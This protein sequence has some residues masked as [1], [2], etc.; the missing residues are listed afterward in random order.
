MNKE[1]LRVIPMEENFMGDK[2]IYDTVWGFFQLNSYK[3]NNGERFVY[4]TN[5]TTPTNI[6]RSIQKVVGYKP[7]GKEIYN[8]SLS[9]VKN[10]IQI[11]KK[12]GLIWEGK[13]KDNYNREVDV[14]FLKSDFKKFQYINYETLRFLL[15]STNGNTIKIYVYLLYKQEWKQKKNEQYVF[16]KKELGKVLGYSD[17][18]NTNT[19]IDDILLNLKNNGLID[20]IEYYE[21][22]KMGQPMKQHKVIYTSTKVKGMK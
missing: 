6:L 5:E 15:N 1:Q 22:N 16:T 13:T 8:I 4:K 11:Y 20:W 12:L 10:N 7:N 9:T 18:N 21:N 17:N 3:N 2:K 19:M 14:Y